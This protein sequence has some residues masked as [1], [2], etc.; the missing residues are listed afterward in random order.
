M[1]LN[2]AIGEKLLGISDTICDLFKQSKL[3]AYHGRL[4]CWKLIAV[5][6]TFEHTN[7][8]AI[9]TQFA[10]EVLITTDLISQ[11]HGALHAPRSD[12]SNEARK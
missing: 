3:S 10:K 11:V 1:F 4:V 12:N 2:D 8:D 7:K 9:L 6:L 5:S